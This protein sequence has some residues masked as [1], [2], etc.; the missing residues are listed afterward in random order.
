MRN[1]TIRML[2]AVGG[3]A[4]LTACSFGTAPPAGGVAAGE[5]AAG[6]GSPESMPQSVNSL[7][8]GAATSSVNTPSE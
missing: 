7:P 2:I 3:L 4:L 5:V 6:G 1:V 8:V